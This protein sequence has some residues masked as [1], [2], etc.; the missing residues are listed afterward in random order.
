MCD[1]NYSAIWSS[2][3]D[4]SEGKGR[5]LRVRDRNEERDGNVENGQ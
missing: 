5:A 2:N 3:L 1:L 4:A